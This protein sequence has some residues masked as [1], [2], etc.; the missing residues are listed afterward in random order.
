MPNICL[1][2][3]SCV[4]VWGCHH[5]YPRLGGLNSRSL[6]SHSSEGWK[7]SIRVPAWLGSDEN[8]LSGLQMQPSHYICTLPRGKRVQGEK[9]MELSVVSFYKSINPIRRI[10]PSWLHVNLI[11]FQS[12]LSRPLGDTNIHNFSHA[13]NE[14]MHACVLSHFS[15]VRL[16][17]TVMDHSPPGFPVYGILQ[18]RTVE[19]IAM[20]SSRG[21]PK[22]RDRTHI[23]YVS[24][25]V[26]H[27]L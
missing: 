12:H 14:S 19:Q 25:I 13:V 21:S 7:S 15:R 3:N 8:F 16:F 24:C 6:L 10:L 17:A 22:P 11:T 20:S 9:E 23:S 27:V 4:L 2:R 18:A 5:K 1:T 26:R